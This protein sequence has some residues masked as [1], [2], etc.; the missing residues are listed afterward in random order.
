MEADAAVAEA[1]AAVTAQQV[2]VAAAVINYK[3]NSG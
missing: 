2:V 3:N 1:I